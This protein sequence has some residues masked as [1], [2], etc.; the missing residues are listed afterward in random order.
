[1]RDAIAAERRGIPCVLVLNRALEN[2]V[3]ETARVDCM[4]D[5]P[6]VAVAEPLFGRERGEI[7]EIG[8]VRGE[9]VE[10]ALVGL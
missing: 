8:N 4:P 9:A 7:A 1:M 3:D 2:I 6:V 10:R 5:V